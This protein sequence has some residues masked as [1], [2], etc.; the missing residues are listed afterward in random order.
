MHI[1]HRRQS[2]TTWWRRVARLR[3][4][5]DITLTGSSWTMTSR[6]QQTCWRRW[7][8]GWKMNLSGYLLA[9]CRR[10]EHLLQKLFHTTSHVSCCLL[11]VSNHDGY[12][13]QH[14]ILEISSSLYSKPFC[15]TC[16]PFRIT[17]EFTRL[18]TTMY[19]MQLHVL[20]LV[21]RMGSFVF[22]SC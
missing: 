19:T 5:M 11:L 2:Y 20:L 16:C 22:L 4:S 13:L 17:V 10:C 6:L 1:S 7:Q 14:I 8:E 15:M 21:F 18:S 3:P 12:V 9:G